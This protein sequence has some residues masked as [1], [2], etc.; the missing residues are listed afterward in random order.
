MRTL[1]LSNYDALHL[2]IALSAGVHAFLTVDD[3]IIRR[4]SKA[5]SGQIMV[6]NP[7]DWAYRNL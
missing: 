4:A 7:L 1:G 3:G 2:S 6:T 5:L